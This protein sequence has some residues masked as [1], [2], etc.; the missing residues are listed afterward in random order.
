MNRTPNLMKRLSITLSILQFCSTGPKQAV[1]SA[2]QIFQ[3]QPTIW[4]QRISWDGV[5]WWES[6]PK[7]ITKHCWHQVVFPSEKPIGKHIMWFPKDFSGENTKSFSERKIWETHE[8]F[9]G[10][11][12][13]IFFMFLLRFFFEKHARNTY[14]VSCMFPKEIFYLFLSVF[15]KNNFLILLFIF[16]TDKFLFYL[17]DIPYRNT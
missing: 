10:F 9:L 17:I 4:L 2:I 6:I 11:F 1:V 7:A 14:C 12:Q 16:P 13:R 5:I 3:P 15:L 8:M